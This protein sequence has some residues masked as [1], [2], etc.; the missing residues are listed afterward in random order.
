MK[1]H[2]NPWEKRL[3]IYTSE[4][5]ASREDAYHYPYE[6][7]SYAVLERL[8]ESDYISR[9]NI[10]LDSNKMMK[11]RDIKRQQKTMVR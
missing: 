3:N 4:C 8:A 1:Q 9:E 2:L 7:T 10:G 11:C 5:D 6:P